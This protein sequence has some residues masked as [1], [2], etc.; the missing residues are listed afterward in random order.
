M[1]SHQRNGKELK[2]FLKSEKSLKTYGRKSAKEKYQRVNFEKRASAINKQLTPYQET[3]EQSSREF[4]RHSNIKTNS[5]SV[6]IWTAKRQVQIIET[7]KV[8]KVIQ[9]ELKKLQK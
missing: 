4:R 5:Q 6:Y 9:T 2:D 3:F 1:A 8:T 7:Q